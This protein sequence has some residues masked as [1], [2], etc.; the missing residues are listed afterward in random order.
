MKTVRYLQGMGEPKGPGIKTGDVVKVSN[1]EAERLI[2][3]NIAVEC[4]GKAPADTGAPKE[5]PEPYKGYGDDDARAI[6]DKVEAGELELEELIALKAAEKA[7]DNRKT[8]LE[9]VEERLDA[10]LTATK[11]RSEVQVPEG[12]TPGETPG[13]PVDAVSGEILD[14]PDQVREE[15][16]SAAI[17]AAHEEEEADVKSPAE[18]GDTASSKKSEG[19]SKATSQKATRAKGKPS[20]KAN[21]GSSR[22]RS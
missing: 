16:T 20:R 21:K 7:G 4:D 2:E 6:I 14:L 1:E 11:P 8:V 13:W 3:K 17:A 12:V 18:T 15:L 9:V 10:A 22:K 5:S 19:A